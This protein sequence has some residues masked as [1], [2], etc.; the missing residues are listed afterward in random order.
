MDKDI[1]ATLQARKALGLWR[2][3]LVIESPEGRTIRIGNQD[4]LQFASNDYLGL[5]NHPS[6]KKA[7]IE[8]I[9]AYGVGAGGSH[10]LSGHKRPHHLLEQR[11][12][13]FIG[14]PQALLFSSGY[15]ANL[16]VV[17]TLAENGV[18]FADRL[19]H[20]SLNDAVLLAR[21]KLYRY[22]HLDLEHLEKFLKQTTARKKM[23]A[24]DAVFS[25]DGDLAPL[26]QLL[27]LAKRYECWLYVDDAHGFGVLGQ[28]KGSLAHFGLDDEQI[29]YMGTLGKAAGA[30][31]AFVAAESLIVELLL[32]T[33]K[34]YIY[35]TA[36]PPALAQA[37]LQSLKLIEDG[38]NLRHRIAAHK[39]QF[40]ALFGLAETPSA[41]APLLIGDAN[42]TVELSEALWAKRI[43]VP[44]IRP[45]T[46]PQ[47]ASRLR[48]SFSAAHRA[49]DID[50]LSVNL[51]YFLSRR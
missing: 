22:R 13:A 48:I 3:R 27:E 10:L 14:K 20:A 5:A 50:C 31:G 15:S 42:A 16:A 45:P 6:I 41:I 36:M 9:D 49:E 8:G 47:G 1:L 34:T 12:A 29:I 43:F 25:M 21:A 39:K 46:V 32:Q 11:L 37:L 26:P 19:N 44:A 30:M 7:M 24:T 4:Y 17:R 33:A 40:A 35:T 28:G 51:R 23:I 18:V 38:E 2:Q